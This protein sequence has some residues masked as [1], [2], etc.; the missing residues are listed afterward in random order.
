MKVA[1]FSF[2]FRNFEQQGIQLIVFQIGEVKNSPFIVSEKLE[3]DCL[4]ILHE[5]KYQYNVGLMTDPNQT[6]GYYGT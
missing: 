5:K 1:F 2:N 4:K 6:S 3:R